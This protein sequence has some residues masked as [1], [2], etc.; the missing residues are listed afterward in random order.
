[1]IKN[2]VM[3]FSEIPK[4][5]KGYKWKNSE[6]CQIKYKYNE[7]EGIIEVLKYNNP[8]N[9]LVKCNDNIMQTSSDSLINGHIGTIIKVI[10]SDFKYK[11][12]EIVQCKYQSVKILNRYKIDNNNKT[13]KYYDYECLKCGYIKLKVMECSLSNGYGCPCC[14]GKIVVEGIND[15]PTTAPWMVDYF[16]GG[17]EEA[18]LYHKT[19]HKLIIPKCPI[20]NKISSKEKHISDIY[21]LHSIGCQCDGKMSFPELIMYNILEQNN[22]DFIIQVTNKILDWAESYRYDF[23]LPTYNCIIET[24]GCQ[25]YKRTKLIGRTLEE[26]QQNDINKKKL[27]VENGI[28]HYFEVDCRESSVQWILNSCKKCGLFDFLSIDIEKI[29]FTN[30]FHKKYN[31]KII[32][33]RDIVSK[34]PNICFSELMKKL[35][36]VHYYDLQKCLDINN[37]TVRSSHN[38]PVDLFKDGVFFMSFSSLSE[39][40]K[41]TKGTDWFSGCRA[42]LKNRI[43]NGIII[44]ERYQYKYHFINSEFNAGEVIEE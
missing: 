14:A 32:E 8:Q 27:A 35:G 41:K 34:N 22:I 11:I 13:N 37:L 38:T 30:L 5:S 44:N 6:G 7:Y 3:D 9:I 26:E 24:H 4:N 29:N 16:Q 39:V 20:C 42:T 12:N 17:Y 40:Y 28:E 33:C 18:K 2:C 1:M 43:E 19:S 10:T 21:H 36:F 31:D 15:I 25:H 23:Y